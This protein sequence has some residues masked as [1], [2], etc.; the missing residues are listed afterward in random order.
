V[1]WITQVRITELFAIAQS[2]LRIQFRKSVI[3]QPM[4]RVRG[5]ATGV[6][7]MVDSIASARS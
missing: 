1:P 6:P 5:R 2:S 7:E 3:E 4:G